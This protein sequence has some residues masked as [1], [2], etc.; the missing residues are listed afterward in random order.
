MRFV[1]RAVVALA[2]LA[3]PLASV[4]HAQAYEGVLLTTDKNPVVDA[5]IFLMNSRGYAADTA[6]TNA[7]GEFRV[8]TTTAGKY[9]LTIRRL[10]FAPEQSRFFT[11]D[12][13]QT[14]RDTL[15]INFTRLLRSVE[16][17]VREQVKHLVG[18]DVKQ[19]GRRFITPDQVDSIRVGAKGLPDFIHRAATPGIWIEREGTDNIC[20]KTQMQSGCA[21]LYVDGVRT[22]SNIEIS[23]MDIESIILL[24]PN[25]G[26]SVTGDPGGSVLVYTRKTISRAN[27]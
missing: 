8:A 12:T 2:A 20:Y 6:H 1:V 10:G 15:V 25:E 16:V 9:A 21:Q 4:A 14:I 27:R 26:F 17:V 13:D 18:I 19:L 7:R 22:A 24:R 11:L 3:G 23:P 5:R